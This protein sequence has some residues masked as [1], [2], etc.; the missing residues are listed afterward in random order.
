[1]R[2]IA[3]L[4][5]LLTIVAL[6]FSPLLVGNPSLASGNHSTE[7]GKHEGKEKEF[8]AG[9]MIFEH[10]LDSHDWHLFS[11]YSI[12]LPVILYHPDRGFS[13]FM[14]SKFN[15]GHDAYKGYKI[16]YVVDKDGKKS[17]APKLVAVDEHG[18]YD[19]KATAGIWDFSITKNVMSLLIS[20][21]VMLWIFLSIAKAY[22]KNALQAPKGKQSFFEPLII[23][24]RDDIAKAVIPNGKHNKF[25]PFLLTVFFFIWINNMMGLIPIFPGGVNLTGSISITLVLALITF[26][27]T[28]FSG[29]K[30]YWRH[31]VAMPGVPI[32]V[33]IILTPI[34]ILSMFLK[35]FVLM[36]RLFANITAGHI[37]ALSFFGLI[38]IFG[39]MNAGA[40]FGVSV[41]SVAFTVFMMVLELL[42]AFL[43]AYVF[44]LLSAI[45]FG[46]AVE[47]AHH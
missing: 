27:I 24:V 18:E 43:Q 39:E 16:Q 7:E 3:G 28:T 37:I 32:G 13:F 22:R 30:H 8:N 1:M 29:N 17:L 15:H 35:P 34:E 36:V 19:E 11:H 23:F 26:I 46:A 21:G 45:Y 41:L 42:V 47:E 4:G 6:I 12:P 10:I 14:S 9:D 5:A 2:K 25:L 31:I 38:F 40:G 33:L 44:A 20:L